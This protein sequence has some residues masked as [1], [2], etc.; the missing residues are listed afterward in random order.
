VVIREES[1]IKK[2]ARE[3]YNLQVSKSRGWPH[4]GL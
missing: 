4:H 1:D 2:V 3:L